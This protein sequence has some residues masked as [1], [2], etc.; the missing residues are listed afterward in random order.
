MT[1]AQAPGTAQRR[2]AIPTPTLRHGWPRTSYRLDFVG[3][4]LDIFDG[5]VLANGR[6]EGLD[7]AATRDGGRGGQYDSRSGCVL[8]DLLVS[9]PCMRLLQVVRRVSIM[10]RFR[11]CR[12]DTTPAMICVLRLVYRCPKTRCCRRS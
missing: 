6:P 10:G 5:T 2:S 1:Q 8:G 9:F 12:L 3:F 7:S 4:P 11:L